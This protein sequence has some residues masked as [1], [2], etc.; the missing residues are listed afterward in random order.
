MKVLI[1]ILIGLLVVGCGKKE[2][3]NTGVVNPNKLSPKAVPANVDN[4][5]L[6]KAIRKSIKKHTGELSKKDLEKVER[7]DLGMGLTN[8]KLTE[9]PK[10]LEK[11]TKLTNLLL[12]DN[13]LTDV[14]GLEKLTKLT[15]LALN[16]NQLTDVKGLE[17][18]T[19][20]T[21]LALN[22]NQLTDVKGLEK[23]T[24]LKKLFLGYNYLTDV[25]DLEKLNQ[26]KNLYLRGNR[27]LTKAQI[28]ELQKALP[29]CK[30]DHNAK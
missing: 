17:K 8:N 12:S 20:L 2:D 29:N 25:K 15:S 27:N 3:G 19:K 16:R 10:G 26:L 11:L 18:L 21:G 13:K 6:E 28:D 4:P 30:I 9:V 14:E 24:Q 5:I 23:L 1:P 7:L 22:D